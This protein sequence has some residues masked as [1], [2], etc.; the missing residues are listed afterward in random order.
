MSP[1]K[2]F[3]LPHLVVCL[4][5]SIAC[6]ELSTVLPILTLR[7]PPRLAGNQHGDRTRAD[8]SGREGGKGRRGTRTLSRE[9]GRGWQGAQGGGSERAEKA[10]K[11]NGGWVGGGK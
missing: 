11:I 7:R 1:T 3:P 6:F 10:G 9:G 2:F 8:I 5:A 4:V